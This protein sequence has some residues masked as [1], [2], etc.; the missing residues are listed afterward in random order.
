MN[1]QHHPR[2]KKGSILVLTAILMILMFAFLAFA[3]DLGYLAMAR[4]QLQ[5]T[6]DSAAIA[7]AGSL[8]DAEIATGQPNSPAAI[9]M[10]SPR[11]K[12]T[13]ASIKY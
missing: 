10:Q 2:R 13:L 7:A 6:A 1:T 8:L 12:I 11:P 9:N 4:T 5:R 3:V